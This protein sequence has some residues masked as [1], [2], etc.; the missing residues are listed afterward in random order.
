MDKKGLIIVISG[1]SGAGKTTVCKEILKRIKNTVFSVSATTRKPRKGEIQGRDYFF[2]SKEKFKEMI[3]NKDLI[4]WA[5]VHNNYYGTPKKFLQKTINSGKDI[6]L[7]I[8]V[9]G[10]RKIKKLYPKGVFI[11]LMPSSLKA[12]EQRIRKRAQDDEKTI[13]IRMKNVKKEISYM[14][15]YTY[16]VIN[17]K[18]N[19]AVEDIISII[20]A[21]H[22]KIERLNLR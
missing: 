12:L 6:I 13:K 9:Q 4:E 15:D 2:V 18:L 8:D 10:G 19:D 3:R 21:E 5:I 14:S 1:P 16:L 20:K 17:D 11:F 22:R 7:D